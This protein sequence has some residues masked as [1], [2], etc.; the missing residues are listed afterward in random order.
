M[1]HCKLQN[2]IKPGYT[3]KNARTSV[4]AKHT[5]R[6][7]LLTFV[8]KSTQA[9]SCVNLKQNSSVS[10]TVSAFIIRGWCD[11]SPRAVLYASVDQSIYTYLCGLSFSRLSAE[12]E[13]GP[14]WIYKYRRMRISGNSSYLPHHPLSIQTVSESVEF[15]GWT[16]LMTQTTSDNCEI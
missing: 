5:N 3:G 1:R 14:R 8:I 9:I 15:C 4:R 2:A 6:H 7:N 13:W 11:G 16:W 12:L 10:E